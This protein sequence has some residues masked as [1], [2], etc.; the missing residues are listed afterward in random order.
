LGNGEFADFHRCHREGKQSTDNFTI[1][2][3][4]PVK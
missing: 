3:I 2:L 4:L 1:N